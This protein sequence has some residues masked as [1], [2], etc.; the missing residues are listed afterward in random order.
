M[1]HNRIFIVACIHLLQSLD[2][3]RDAREALCGPTGTWGF[4][5]P[6]GATSATP[7]FS[8]TKTGLGQA[9]LTEQGT[10]VLR[11]QSTV[12]NC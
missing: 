3:L 9:H 8:A 1:P 4:R 2:L 7:D 5:S 11:L 6:S 12:S 10:E